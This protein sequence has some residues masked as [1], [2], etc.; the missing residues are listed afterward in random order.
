MQNRNTGN[1]NGFIHLASSWFCVFYSSPGLDLFRIGLAYRYTLMRS[2]S[3]CLDMELERHQIKES[4]PECVVL[5]H[6]PI[7][8]DQSGKHMEKGI[9]AFLEYISFFPTYHCGPIVPFKVFNTTI[10]LQN[11]YIAH[12]EEILLL[13]LDGLIMLFIEIASRTFYFPQ[14]LLQE[15]FQT[16]NAFE[17]WLLLTSFLSMAFWESHLPF[18]LARFCSHMCGVNAPRETPLLLWS[19]TSSMR[20]FCRRFHVSWHRWLVEYIYKPC[21]GGVYG[22]AMSLLVS[23]FLH[24]ARR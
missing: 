8:N 19:C 7:G 22:A 21:S 11:K 1:V 4:M 6:K 14:T 3:Y 10:T 12:T 18:S 20:E 17:G 15:S 23:L 2:T 16:L 24:G 5:N 13:V 9:F